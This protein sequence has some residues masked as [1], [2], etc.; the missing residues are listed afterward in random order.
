MTQIEAEF[1][2]H[3]LDDLEN[4]QITLYPFV[5]VRH[6]LDDLEI[7]KL[8]INNRLSVRH[9]LDDLENQP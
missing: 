1:V 5:E 8:F 9:R 4:D 7:V 3:R 2:R 6:R